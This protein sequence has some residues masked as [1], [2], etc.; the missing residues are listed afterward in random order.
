MRSLSPQAARRDPAPSRAA[1]RFQRLWLTPLFRSLVR[2]GLPS[3]ALV[4]GLGAYLTDEATQDMLNGAIADLRASVAE[5]PEFTINLMAIDGASDGLAEDLREILALD[6]PLSSF[7]LDLDAIH[8]RVSGL[9]AVASARL[10]VRS[11]GILSV[12]IVERVPAVV[13]RTADLLELLDAEGR[14][15]AAIDSRL[16]RPDLP[17]L[18]GNGADAAVPQALDIL[19]AAAPVADRLRGLVRMGERR[20]DLVLDGD[21]RI[22]LPEAAPIIALEKVI[23]LDKAQDLLARDISVIDMRNP[24]RPTLRLAEPALQELTRIRA[25]ERGGQSR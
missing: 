10:Q 14:R 13:W 12:E 22:Q 7:D 25:I 24:A 20:W 21:Q 16:A 3:F 1:Y 4:I 18:A 6:F 11:G 15:V 8:E 17:L 5:R 9:D 19:A 2:T 23:A